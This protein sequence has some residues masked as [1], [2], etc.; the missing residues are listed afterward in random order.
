MCRL[1]FG[2]KSTFSFGAEVNNASPVRQKVKRSHVVSSGIKTN[3][4]IDWKAIFRPLP[5]TKET[6]TLAG[7]ESIPTTAKVRVS[8][9]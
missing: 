2:S 6:T 5:H 8:P 3:L 7:I 1:E 4:S 9:S